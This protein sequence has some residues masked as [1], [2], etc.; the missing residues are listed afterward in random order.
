M[1]HLTH[2]IS[3][4]RSRLRRVLATLSLI[5]GF[6][7]MPSSAWAGLALTDCAY[8]GASVAGS[9]NISISS[10]SVGQEV[11]TRTFTVELRNCLLSTS[12]GSLLFIQLPFNTSGLGNLV[13]A[14]V[15]VTSSTGGPPV[16]SSNW[17]GVGCNP[18]LGYGS[19]TGST[20]F[21][22]F[23]GCASGL[24]GNL[25][26]TSTVRFLYNGAGGTVGT[27]RFADAYSFPGWARLMEASDG[28]GNTQS[29]YGTAPLNFVVK[30]CATVPVTLS[31]RLPT[32]KDTDLPSVG[33][34]AGTTPINISLTG[35]PELQDVYVPSM[36]VDFTNGPS[37]YTM[38][39]N[40]SSAAASGVYMQ[41]LTTGM[42]AMASG[43]SVVLSPI[44]P[45]SSNS[46]SSSYTM[47]AR[48][49]RAGP[50]TSGRVES[51]ATL[52]YTYP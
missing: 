19:G 13:G 26:L 35:C 38:A 45:G 41:L 15:Q 22:D 44:L 50:V 33:S 27:T 16:L 28:T 52:T 36:R 40:A 43:S 8:Y 25:S 34:T 30:K 32:I 5:A 9:S 20:W 12:P 42:A 39:N 3:H 21:V 49:Y 48:Y 6:F 17:P 1:I 24:R 18:S 11:A 46:A 51:V 10:L 47:Y 31:V 23:T 7:A 37:A 4:Q 2:R 29:I 14:G